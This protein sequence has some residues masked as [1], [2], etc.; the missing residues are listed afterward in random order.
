MIRKSIPAWMLWLIALACVLL[1]VFSKIKFDWTSMWSQ[2][3]FL[4]VPKVIIAIALIYAS[5]SLRALRWAVLLRPTKKVES[6]RLVSSQFIGFTC[7]ALF[8]SLGDLVR[9]CMLAR[10]VS[11]PVSSLIAT[12]TI[13]RAFD[14][15]AAAAVFLLSQV[16]AQSAQGTMYSH[17]LIRL[18][19]VSVVAM[20]MIFAVAMLVRKTGTR[21]ADWTERKLESLSPRLA[22]IAASKIQ[23][24]TDG[25][26]AVTS[27]Q[28]LL[29]ITAVSLMI[30]GLIAEAFFQVVHAFVKIPELSMLT[31]SQTMILVAASIG[32]SFVQFPVVGW[33]TQIAATAVTMHVLLGVPLEPATA[34]G[35]LLLASTFLFLIPAGLVF[36][37]LNGFTIQ[38]TLRMS[39]RM[40]G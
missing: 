13:E 7:V 22:T 20:L 36:A 18:G 4:S 26:H 21:I 17:T 3:R 23:L 5:V 35:A 8:G 28:D 32:G 30:W 39:S 16:L 15:G 27:V 38:S 12:Y 1:F 34:C 9:P 11:M 37:Y 31:F 10:R 33:F 14:L 24:F 29:K 2:L 6:M 25:M 19:G 40:D